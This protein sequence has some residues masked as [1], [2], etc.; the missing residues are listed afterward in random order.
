MAAPP[1]RLTHAAL[2]QVLPFVYT[3]MV[4]LSCT[5]YL[6]GSAFLKGLE[7]TQDASYTGAR[8][9]DGAEPIWSPSDTTRAATAHGP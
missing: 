8:D 3:H 4:S 7:F 2:A 9:A 1:I 5:I 6:C